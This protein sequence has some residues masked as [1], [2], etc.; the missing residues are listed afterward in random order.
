MLHENPLM[1]NI[2][3]D[4][5]RNLQHL[6]LES[7]RE[8]CRIIIIHEKG[9]IMKFVHSKRHEIIKS[10]DRVDDAAKVAE[11]VYR[12]NAENTDFVLV[13]E[14]KSVEDF[15]AKVQDSW[16]A[17]EDLDVYVHRMFK[18][19]D[20]YP[21]GIVT[22]PGSARSNLGLQWRLGSKYEDI[23]EAIKRFIPAESSIVFGVFDEDILWT[24]LVLGFDIDK[25][26]NN[27]TTVDPTELDQSGKWQDQ[28]IKM[29][30]WVNHKYP[31]CS[32]GIFT[33]LKEVG[34]ILKSKDKFDV[35]FKLKRE[36]KLLLEPVTE[37]LK[38]LI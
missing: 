22:F 34:Q 37:L 7:S 25:K 9:E 8:K 17:E 26:I 4:H 28:A 12:D 14:R 32:L 10:V 36:G 1:T 33:S 38:P 24:S 20:D 35:I 2:D 15:F 23:D 18:S 11:Q 31:R 19:L 3:V 16:K 27:I 29:I 5:W 13:I 6:V 30:D 21:E